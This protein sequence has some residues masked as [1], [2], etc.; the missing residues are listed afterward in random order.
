MVPRHMKAAIDRYVDEGCPVA[1]FLY[2]VLTNNLFEAAGRADQY[3]RP[4][5]AD[6]CEYIY[7]YTPDTCHGSPEEVK[8]WLARHRDNPEETHRAAGGD[9][10]KRAQYCEGVF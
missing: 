7:N 1:S 4:L 2:A 9:R 3:N 6:I 8:A 5:L 10:E